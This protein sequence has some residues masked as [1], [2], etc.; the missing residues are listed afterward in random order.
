M[1]RNSFINCIFSGTLIQK[2]VHNRTEESLPMEHLAKPLYSG[3]LFKQSLHQNEISLDLDGSGGS[4]LY[5]WAGEEFAKAGISLDRRD[6]IWHG[7]T[8][9][10]DKTCHHD[11][12]TKEM[13]N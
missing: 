6:K 11:K 3:K 1:E 9:D 10:G 12:R 7:G 13:H 8:I 4:A 5:S 2:S